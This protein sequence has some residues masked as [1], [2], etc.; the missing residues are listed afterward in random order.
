MHDGRSQAAGPGQAGRP[1]RLPV[2]RPAD[3]DRAGCS[4]RSSSA[5]ASAAARRRCTARSPRTRPCSRPCCTRACTTSTSATTTGCAGTAAHFP[6]QRRAERVAGTL[7]RPGA[8]LRVQPVLHVPPARGA[9]GSPTTCPTCALVVLVRDPVE[10]AYSQ[11]AHEVARG[12]ETERDFAAR[13]RAR[14]GPAARQARR[15]DRGPDVLQLRAPAPR[16]PGPRRVRRATCD[17]MAQLLGRDRIHVVESERVLH[18]AGEVVYDEVLRLPRPA[19]HLAAYP[20]FERHN[21]R[22][23]GRHARTASAAALTEYYAPYDARL[24]AAGS[25]RTRRGAAMTATFAVAPHRGRPA[26]HAPQRRSWWAGQPGRHGASPASPGSRSPGSS[27]A[28]SSRRQAGAFFGATATF[29]L[30]VAAWPSSARQTGAGLLAGPAAGDRRRSSG[31]GALPA[32]RPRPGGAGRARGRRPGCGSARPAIAR[33]RARNPRTR[34]RRL[35]AL[36]VFLP[37]AAAHR[38]RCSPPPAASGSCGRR[39]CSTGSCGRA[40][41]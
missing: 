19:P 12:F 7:R 18:R 28:P 40:P 8:D 30:G 13:A 20:P 10:R 4:R 22:P 38:R 16:L 36:A 17:A 14:A 35:R 32:H 39:C 34:D 26:R 6:L 37:A 3:R 15:A 33:R 21:A 24:S 23:R 1:R 2:V 41:S 9:P 25:A 31:L 29:V 5:A 11:H 27:P